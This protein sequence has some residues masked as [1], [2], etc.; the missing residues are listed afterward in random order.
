MVDPRGVTPLRNDYDATGRLVR[1]TDATGKTVIY[2]HNVDG[3]VEAITDRLG[4][5]T[6]H[7][8]D[9]A[10]QRAFDHGRQRRVPALP[11]TQII[12]S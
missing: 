3:K 6:T 1:S 10:G 2:S 12:T 8:Y 4:H 11:T 9:D 5:S 7:R